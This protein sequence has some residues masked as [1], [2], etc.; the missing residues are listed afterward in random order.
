MTHA[1]IAVDETA[2]A[3]I[4]ANYAASKLH[5]I[6][7]DGT[8]RWEA[9]G[10]RPY[11]VALDP[12]LREVYV[13]DYEGDLVHVFNADSGNLLRSWTPAGFDHPGSLSFVS[14]DHIWI[15]PDS[16]A[17][18]TIK[19]FNRAGVPTGRQVVA[20]EGEI[21]SIWASSTTVYVAQYGGSGAIY[22]INIGSGAHTPFPGPIAAGTFIGH[23]AGDEAHDAVFH[24]SP[25]P[26]S[27]DE[28]NLA[29][30]TLK[31]LVL[32]GSLPG[33]CA[34]ITRLTTTK[35][36]MSVTPHWIAYRTG[37]AFELVARG[38][39]QAQVS[40]ILSPFDSI[41]RS[42]IVSGALG[43]ELDASNDQRKTRLFYS[44]DN[45][46]TPVEFNPSDVLSILVAAGVPF[47]VGVSMNNV[48][49]GGDSIP[50][51]ISSLQIL[52]DDGV[53]HYVPKTTSSFSVTV[54]ALTAGSMNMDLT[55][56]KLLTQG[57]KPIVLGEDYLLR[58]RFL[59]ALGDPVDF[60]NFDV[61]MTIVDAKTTLA[62]S[63]L[64]GGAQI[65]DQGLAA[66][67][68]DLLFQASDL[69]QVSGG[70]PL[71]F[72]IQMRTPTGSRIVLGRGTISFYELI[73]SLL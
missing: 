40:S 62:K 45:G 24:L 20:V 49:I 43:N 59:D 38:T 13:T 12:V 60:T 5:C 16:P 18:T 57:I 47:T 2:Q 70:R 67:W 48:G 34:G 25:S 8:V 19:E 73:G 28:S 4:V 41:V 26:G 50:P 54:G 30:S 29:L 52:L 14:T 58:L 39:Q 35:L 72:Q 32:H 11:G 69:G 64:A 61:K 17:I 51:Y 9:T 63:S 55:V 22:G 10:F 31:P 42:V 36:G 71:A 37:Y 27:V 68:I 33:Q 3:V 46:V 65:E 66:G 23:L 15:A 21:L 7:F 44:L 1:D 6:A 53:I 56:E